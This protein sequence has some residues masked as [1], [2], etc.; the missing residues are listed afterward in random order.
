MR[1]RSNDARSMLSL[2]ILVIAS[3]AGDPS[4]AGESRDPAA[5]N[6]IWIWADNL[7]YADLGCYGSKTI[8]TPVIDR[9][10]E[11]GA[12]F[13]QYYVAHTVCSPSRAALLTGRQ[14]F[15]AGVVDVLRP[16]GPS[17][18]P[19]EEI[20]L[21]AA[22]R[23]QGYAT[24]AVGKWHLGDRREYLPLQRGFDRYLGLPYSMDM[25]PTV[26]YR[27]NEIAEELPGDKVQDVTEKFTDA[28][29]DFIKTNKHRP[30]FIYFNHTIPHPPLNLPPKRRTPGRSIYDDAIE[31][32]DDEV[33]RLLKTLDEL[34]LTDNT[35]VLF[36]SDNGPMV[37]EGDTGGLRGGIRDSYEG[38]LRV[39]LVACWPGKIPAGRT[40]DTPAIAY[41]VFP[42]LVDLSGGQVPN[43]RVYDG[44]NIWPLLSGKGDF[45]RQRPFF[46]VYLDNVTA[47]RDGKWK[48]H[49][50]NRAKRLDTP[51]L[52]DLDADPGERH[53][54]NKK[55]TDVVKRL[56]EA[57]R[58]FQSDV[59][60]VWDLKYPVRDPAKRPSGIR[61][62]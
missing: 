45:K 54:L 4:V 9:L 24:M 43:D 56:Q 23:K 16:D 15:R 19:A 37:K 46:W 6:I 51:E 52:Y 28:A 26:L 41:D 53:N 61:R 44:Q 36:S 32:M 14:P 50:G 49:V 27:D 3:L 38:G 40:I 33:G 62:K 17:G 35:L 30:F 58:A 31:Y 22:I 5:P 1:D 21:A 11:R 42:T 39:P 34:A 18:L 25:L 29:I 2:I 7:A 8:K 60:M 57:V 48:L 47:I 13:T 20:T 10:A 12:R 59:P 55:H